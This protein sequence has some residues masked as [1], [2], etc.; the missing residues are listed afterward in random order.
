MCAMLKTDFVS[1]FALPVF[2]LDSALNFSEINASFFEI[3]GDVQGKP[4][5]S[6]SDEFNERKCVRKISAGQAYR[7]KIFTSDVRETS[8]SVELRQTASGYIG[9][10]VEAADAAKAE[11]MLAS[12][13]EMMEK[14]NRILKAEKNKSEKLLQS[15]LPATFIDEL[16]SLSGTTPKTMKKAGLLMVAL[17]QVQHLLD[18]MEAD[19]MFAELDELFTCFDL[20]AEIHACQ[21]LEATP[22]SYL[23]A[24]PL[25]SPDSPAC[26]TLAQFALDAIEVIK[27]RQSQIHIP[28]KFGLHLGEVTTGIVGKTHLSF[29]AM[30]TGVAAVADITGQADDLQVCCS[31]TIYQHSEPLR[32][33]LQ[34]NSNGPDMS[35]K[36]PVYRLSPEFGTRNQEQLQQCISRAKTLRRNF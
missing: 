17:P 23:A 16:Q 34:L 10:A 36:D 6:L 28:C 32:H 11:A 13:S 30:G 9:F 21:R 19:D 35:D 14:Q 33:A 18:G 2:S 5:T 31:D 25:L 20:L 24:L 26:E 1:T 27:L 3:F 8:Y 15:L 12:Y 22:N 7:F 4:I 29:M